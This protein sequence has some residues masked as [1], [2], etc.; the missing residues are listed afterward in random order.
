MDKS[1]LIT[2]G[3]SGIGLCATVALLGRILPAGAL[4]AVARRN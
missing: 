1:I 4:D 3:S 2:G